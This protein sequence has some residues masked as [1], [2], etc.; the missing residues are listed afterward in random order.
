MLFWQI[1]G[2]EGKVLMS[3]PLPAHEFETGSEG[4]FAH[5]GNTT[6]MLGQK[7]HEYSGNIQLVR[8]GSNL[9]PEAVKR[10]ERAKAAK[11]AK[12]AARAAKAAK[13]AAK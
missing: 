11:A 4:F 8:N 12:E 9:E 6:A 2:D 10:V 3:G 7:T 5:V 1:I 13:R